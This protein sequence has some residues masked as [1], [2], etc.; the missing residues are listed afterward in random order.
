MLGTEWRGH[1]KRTEVGE[2][3]GGGDPRISRRHGEDGDEGEVV[4]PEV[5]RGHIAEEVDPHDGV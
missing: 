5:L 1:E 4:G 3:S 2:R